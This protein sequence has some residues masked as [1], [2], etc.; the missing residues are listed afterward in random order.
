MSGPS[1]ATIDNRKNSRIR[2]TALTE[3]QFV[4]E[5][6]VMDNE[7]AV[8]STKIK[9]TVI[10]DSLSSLTVYPNPVKD[11]L[12]ISYQ[13]EKT[14][15]VRIKIFDFNGRVV[16]QSEAQKDNTLLDKSINVSSLKPGIYY[17]QVTSEG[18]KPL[19]QR[20]TRL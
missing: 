6:A 15:V 14:G 11:V 19:I 10:N 1:T 7:G 18:S 20:F 13:K 9:V 3:G 16:L 2:I 8:G 4:F 5:L 12:T 17:L